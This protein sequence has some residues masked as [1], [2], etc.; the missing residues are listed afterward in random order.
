MVGGGEGRVL[1]EDGDS[2]GDLGESYASASSSSKLKSIARTLREDDDEDGSGRKGDSNDVS[3]V[4]KGAAKEV[5]ASSASAAL[6]PSRP[7]ENRNAKAK[8]KSTNRK[9]RTLVD[10][11]NEESQRSPLSESGENAK[12]LLDVSR[13]S[14]SKTLKDVARKDAKERRGAPKGD[15]E[16]AYDEDEEEEILPEPISSPDT[17]KE[18]LSAAFRGDVR[19]ARSACEDSAFVLDSHG[20]SAL[21]WAAAR[22]HRPFVKFLVEECGHPLSAA[23]ELNGWTALHL[24]A[25]NMRY[26]ICEYLLEHGAKSVPDKWGDLPHGKSFLYNNI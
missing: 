3:A 17:R 8:G 22:G 24:A 12:T 23:D 5:A 26:D 9:G 10:V 21:H 1:I 16:G 25:I 20:W 19:S 4:L 7:L 11:A 6:A 14:G 18:I 13:E 2:D 15:S